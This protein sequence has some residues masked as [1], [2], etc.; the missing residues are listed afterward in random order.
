M[1]KFR[2]L[3]LF[4]ALTFMATFTSCGDDDDDA[5]PSE[6][7][8]LTADTW[9]GD[10]VYINGMDFTEEFSESF[11]DIRDS[12][13]KFNADGTYEETFDGDTYSGEWEFS[14]DKRN[15]IFDID[16]PD[17]YT[18]KVEKLTETELYLNESFESEGQTYNVEMRYKH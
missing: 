8:L 17:S 14:S 1:N 18:L 12:N 16:S 6:E 15:I 10:A 2:L 3:S 5:T 13:Y 9:F 4:V 7:A 11:G